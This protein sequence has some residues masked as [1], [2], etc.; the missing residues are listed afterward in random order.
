[1]SKFKVGDR[2]RVKPN[3]YNGYTKG[4]PYNLPKNKDGVILEYYADCS[5]VVS[6]GETVT[7][8]VNGEGFELVTSQGPVRLE[9]RKVIVPGVYGRL[10]VETPSGSSVTISFDKKLGEGGEWVIIDAAGLRAA[11]VVLNELAEALE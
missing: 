11:A 9:T 2:V 4:S 8:P 1:M 10:A 5:I 6:Y 7:P 3:W